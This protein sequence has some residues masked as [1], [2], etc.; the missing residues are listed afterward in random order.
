MAW[1]ARRSRR[2]TRVARITSVLSAR[3]S[4]GQQQNVCAA[5]AGAGADADEDAGAGAGVPRSPPPPEA[6]TRDL[7]FRSGI[8]YHMLSNHLPLKIWRD[9]Q[10]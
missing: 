4:K 6:R 10:D 2:R 8:L 3:A 1:A 5:G 7:P 9:H